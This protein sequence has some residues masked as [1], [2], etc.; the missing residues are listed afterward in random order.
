VIA[1]HDHGR[2]DTASDTGRLLNNDSGRGE[3]KRTT[4]GGRAPVRAVLFMAA[5]VARRFNPVIA[6]LYDRLTQ[7]GK[8][9]MVA[10]VACMRKLLTILNAMKR[11]NRVW[12]PTLATG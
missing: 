6:S 7:N 5:S 1:Q 4:W 11:D 8:V 9:P 3:G 12:T 10:L 2:M